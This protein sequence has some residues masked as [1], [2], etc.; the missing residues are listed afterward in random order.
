VKREPLHLI[1]RWA[2]ITASLSALLFSAAGTTHVAS[3]RRYLL[4]FSAMLLATMFGVDP[5]LANERAHPSNAGVDDRLRFAAGFLF[6]LTLTAAAFSAGR[7]RL[8]FSVPSSL[9]DAA[10]IAFAISGLIQTW[11]MIVNP[12][13]SPLVRLQTERSHS[14]IQ[15]GPYRLMRHPGYFAMSIAIPASALAIGSWIALVPAAA[16]VAC[17]LRRMNLEDD[18]LKKNLCGYLLYATQVRNRILPHL[19]TKRSP[20]YKKFN[21]SGIFTESACN[22]GASKK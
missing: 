3:I 6:L 2:V 4:V 21:V 1:A 10:L 13:F 19:G 5:Q 18:F 16:F 7:L 14:V 11:A 8:G 9:R 22:Q 12:F 20:P 17:V 15:R